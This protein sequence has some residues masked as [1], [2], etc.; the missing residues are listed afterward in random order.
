MKKIISRRDALGVAV[1]ALGGAVLAGSSARAADEQLTI[2]VF[3][4]V[5]GVKGPDGK[6]HDAVVPPSFVVKAGVP[7]H[8][9]IINYDE[10]AHTI[11]CADLSVN[12][13]IAGGKE[14]GGTV[15]PVTTT[16]TITASKR[17]TYRW[18]C[19]LACDAGAKGWAMEQGYGGPSKEGF[20]AGYI[21]VL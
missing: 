19:A 7:T 21:V 4:G 9:Q 16:A 13:Q 17:G 14:V 12:I 11:T 15:T 18:Y 10:G 8:L 6:G 20:M 5:Q 1:G 2:Y 3:R